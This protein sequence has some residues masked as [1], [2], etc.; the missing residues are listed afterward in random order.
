MRTQVEPGG[1]FRVRAAD[2]RP[3]VGVDHTVAVQISELDA[4]RSSAGLGRMRSDVCCILEITVGDVAVECTD[5]VTDLVNC[6]RAVQR[7][8]CGSRAEEERLNAVNGEDGVL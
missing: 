2:N 7:D 5:R 6:F 1:E 3:I 4:T 8:T